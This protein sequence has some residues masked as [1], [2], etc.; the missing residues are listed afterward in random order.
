MKGQS[1]LVW[2][3]IAIAI[4]LTVVMIII[5]SLNTVRYDFENFVIDEEVV[6]VC[7]IVRSGVERLYSPSG[8]SSPE[9]SEMGR[10]ILSLPDRIGSVNYR[11][12]FVNTSLYVAL[13]GRDKNHT[14]LMG[15]N[16]TFA[17]SSAGGETDLVWSRSSSGA[18]AVSIV[19]EADR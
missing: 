4:S 12:T 14:C 15:F 6:Q 19:Q 13:S 2:H 8:Y 7:Q 3:S 5:G 10:I 18:D 1:P 11:A 9:N 17:G 16:I